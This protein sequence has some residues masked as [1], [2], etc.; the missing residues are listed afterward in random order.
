MTAPADFRPSLIRAQDWLA[1]LIAGVRDDQWHNP[2]PCT[3][4][5]VTA[6]VEHLLAV[7][8]RT[9]LLATVGTV[10]GAPR[11][12]PLPVGN[13]ADTLR[14]AFAES[15]P[16]WAAWTPEELGSR[17]VVH[18]I[19][20][21]PGGVAVMMYTEENLTHGWDLA[22]ATGQDAEAPADLVEPVLAFMKNALPAE[23][24]PMMPFADAI[25]PAAD[26]AP[27]ERL[28]NWMGRSR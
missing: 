28:A 17:T 2:T 14:A 8:Q 13:V 6:L 24:P 20:V 11:E 3:E 9:L 27:T 15:R 7:Q 26:A 19:G 18:P 16:A 5:D 1:E 22:V 21:V 25:E 23:R 4:Y 10:E 12:L